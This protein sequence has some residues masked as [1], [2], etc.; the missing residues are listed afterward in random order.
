[1]AR[2]IEEPVR[3]KVYLLEGDRIDGVPAVD[4]ILERVRELGLRGATAYRCFAG[5]GRRGHSEARILRT[6]MNL[7]VVVEV[8]DS[9]EKVE[10]LL[11]LLKERLDVG[12][13][14][15]ERLE[16]AYDLEG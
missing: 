4:W 15:L 8:V 9:L 14:T 6:S 12:V 1:M 16:V 11:E 13:V 7:P 3:L 10:C 2:E 5:C